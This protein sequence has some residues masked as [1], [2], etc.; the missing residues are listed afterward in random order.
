MGAHGWVGFFTIT[1]GSDPERVAGSQVTAGF[2]RTLGVSPSL[3]RLFAPEDDENGAPPTAVL[4]DAF[5][6]RRFGGDPAVLGTIV[7]TRRRAR[8]DKA[9]RERA[10]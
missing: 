10:L 8:T 6:Q 7:E 3:G 5:W 4:T 9:Y 2:F 1:G